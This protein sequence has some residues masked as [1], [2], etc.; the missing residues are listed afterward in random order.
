MFSLSRFVNLQQLNI[1][2]TKGTDRATPYLEN[3]YNLA[4]RAA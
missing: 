1:K 4:M 3:T 2:A